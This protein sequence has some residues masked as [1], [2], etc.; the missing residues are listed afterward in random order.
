MTPPHTDA[1]F[2]RMP[3]EDFEVILARA[4][5]G[6]LLESFEGHKPKLLRCPVERGA[7]QFVLCGGVADLIQGS[8]S[9][10]FGARN[11]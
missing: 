9:D 6:A 10:N 2:V 8:I 1:G 4:A 11:F 3:E 7:G 5:R